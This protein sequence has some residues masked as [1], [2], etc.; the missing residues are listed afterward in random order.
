MYVCVCVCAQ[1]RRQ[2]HVDHCLD[3]IMHLHT[4]RGGDMPKAARVDNSPLLS[5][6]VTQILKLVSAE[7]LLFLNLKRI[8][9]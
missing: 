8:G 6:A 9:V 4:E 2:L 5:F 1:T 7:L 3:R